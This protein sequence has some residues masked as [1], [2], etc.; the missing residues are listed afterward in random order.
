MA[1]IRPIRSAELLQ[2]P[3]IKVLLDEYDAECALTELRPSDPQL[4]LYEVME[5]AGSLKVFGVYDNGYLIGFA[6]VIVYTL[7]HY[8]KK[9]A[10][11]ESIFISKE[12]RHND[13][14]GRLILFIENYAKSS[15]CVAFLYSAPVDSQ[16]AHLLTTN[17]DRYRHTNNVYL[18]SLS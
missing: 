11:T 8:G 14:G 3:D 6:S 9:I 7:P 5:K 4:A 18:R 17:E 15:G 16:F 13:V 10:A 12:H 2:D 1:S